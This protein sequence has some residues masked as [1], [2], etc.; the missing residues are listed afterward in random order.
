MLEDNTQL[1]MQLRDV[2]TGAIAHIG[3]WRER[4]NFVC[5]V[6]RVCSSGWQVDAS[7]CSYRARVLASHGVAA[8]CLRYEKPDAP[9]RAL[10]GRI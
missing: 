4:S 7:R 3:Y 9:R 5:A 6:S 8:D 2:G 10:H 1:M